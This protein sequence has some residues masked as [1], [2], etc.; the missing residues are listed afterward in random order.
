VRSA[1]VIQRRHAQ[2]LVP[3]IALGMLVIGGASPV[4]WAHGLGAHTAKPR[5]GG[6]IA[7]NLGVVLDCADAAKSGEL[8][9]LYVSNAMTDTLI[10]QDDKGKFVGDLAT[11]WTFSHGGKW[12]T[13]SL[14]HGVRFPNGDA[15]DAN[16]VRFNLLRKENTGIIGPVTSVKVDNKYQ[17]TVILSAPSRPAL[18][19]L[20]F[21]MPIYDPKS[22]STNDCRNV[23]GAGPF[24]I[25]SVGPG[26]SSLTMVRN[27]AHNW[28]LS[29]SRNKG[30]AYLSSIKFAAVTDP[31]T[32]VS[33]LL[34]GSL[35]ISAIAGTQL[36]RVQGNK[37][38]KL[39]RKLQQNITWL[40]FNTSHPPF[41]NAQVRKGIAEAVDRS[42]IIRA[43]LNGQGKPAYSM[44]PVSV[45]FSDPKAKSYAVQY[46]PTDAKR[47]LAAHHV[48]GPYTLLGFTGFYAPI[49]EVVQAELAQVGVQ[50]NVVSK[51]LADYFPVASK[52]AFDLNILSY[53]GTDPDT[54]YT[55]F[56]SSQETS[57]GSNYTFYKNA[58]LDSLIVKGRESVN[59]KAAT[60]A[61]DEAQRL[62]DTQ[63]IADPLCT[64]YGVVGVSTRV[65]GY[66][67]NV[68]ALFPDWQDLYIAK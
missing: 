38:I 58:K 28:S 7:F 8:S 21:L 11:K 18:S 65:G 59:K 5:S 37:S 62:I 57:T 55:L 22:I 13:F 68:W 1:P 15:F 49:S 12:I 14:R 34:S 66:H 26:F 54:L 44:V 19:N 3:I 31:A 45:P 42:A 56:H 20:A 23:V 36:S 2:Y 16:V 30:P 27:P 39:Y 60:S 35:D 52:G 61:Y 4:S 48:T 67:R 43:W 47:I 64:P 6:S 17:V 40:G 50:V 9:V 25:S 46:N 33:E 41:D 10:T 53:F 51:P 32:A 24:K 29:Y 63:V